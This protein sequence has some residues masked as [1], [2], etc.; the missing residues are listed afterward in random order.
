TRS[1]AFVLAFLSFQLHFSSFNGAL[2]VPSK[3]HLVFL[4][5]SRYP[6]SSTDCPSHINAFK[7]CASPLTAIT[8]P[9]HKM[10][11]LT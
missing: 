9:S 10:S 8:P 6:A 1:F 7:T 3:S 2:C 5:S 4:S 11:S